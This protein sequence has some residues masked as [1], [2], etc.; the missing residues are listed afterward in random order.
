MSGKQCVVV[1]GSGSPVRRPAEGGHARH[2][3][4]AL[5]PVASSLS[6]AAGQGT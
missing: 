4:G 6:T 5:A 3:A 1:P 2:Q